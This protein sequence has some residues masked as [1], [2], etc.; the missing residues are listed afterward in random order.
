MVTL[1]AV[2]SLV[3]VVGIEYTL[4]IGTIAFF[5]NLYPIQTLLFLFLLGYLKWQGL[6]IRQK[7]INYWN[8]RKPK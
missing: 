3:F 8:K 2:A 4:L 6:V 1:I 7:A 5:I